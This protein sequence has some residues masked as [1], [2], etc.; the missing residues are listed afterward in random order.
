MWIL[1]PWASST[2]NVQYM[3]RQRSLTSLILGNF[4]QRFSHFFHCLSY[5]SVQ[6]S[7]SRMFYFHLLVRHIWHFLRVKRNVQYPYRTRSS[8]SNASASKASSISSI[9]QRLLQQWSLKVQVYNYRMDRLSG[10][11]EVNDDSQ[12]CLSTT[13]LATDVLHNEVNDTNVTY[14][15]R[16]SCQVMYENNTVESNG[17]S[18]RNFYAKI[19]SYFWETSLHHHICIVFAVRPA[20]P[21]VDRISQ[22]KLNLDTNVIVH[23]LT[24]ERVHYLNPFNASCSKLLMF[25]G[26]SAILV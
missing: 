20:L 7:I 26:S 13:S 14:L 25:E 5:K 3:P 10:Y 24:T 11:V 23:A 6:R 2:Y 1:S 15:H 8:A 17:K 21:E 18:H 22:Q 12:T 4:D 16:A 19:Y 9:Y